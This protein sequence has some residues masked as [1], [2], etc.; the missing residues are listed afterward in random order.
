MLTTGDKN[1]LAA[2]VEQT[3]KTRGRNAGGRK[4]TISGDSYY[5]RSLSKLNRLGLVEYLV[6]SVFGTGWAATLAGFNE[7]RNER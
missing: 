2:I 1:V 5:A 6:D 3:C 4:A 7:W